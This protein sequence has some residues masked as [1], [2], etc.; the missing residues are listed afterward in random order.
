MLA[1][2]NR[3]KRSSSVNV[4]STR[5]NGNSYDDNDVNCTEVTASKD[6]S[7]REFSKDFTWVGTAWYCQNR[8]KHYKSFSR[9]GITIS[10]HS[11]VYIMSEEMKRLVAYV[12]DLYEDTNSYNMVK[13]RWFDKVDEVGVPLPMDVN[14][15]EIFFS[16]GRQ[17]L[18]V[19][20]IDGLA[21]VLSAQ[22]FEK[23]KN[24][25]KY[26]NWEPYLCRWQID[27]DEVKPFDISQLQG[28]WSQEV[29]RTMFNAASSLKVRFR[30]TKVGPSCDGGQKRK[31]DEF[32]N[33]A[34]PQKF[35][36]SGASGSDFFK[37]ALYDNRKHIY[38]G[39][40]AEVLSQDSGIR[41]CWFR[42]LILKR[43]RDK[44]KVRYLDLQDADDTG[45]LEEWVMLTRV[46]KPDHLGIRFIGRPM[47]R[48]QRVQ[49]IKVPS[50][51]DVG[52]IVDAWWH[53][54]WW[55]G[56]VL[57][58]GNDRRL[59]VYFPGEKRVAEFGEDDLRYSLEWVGSKWNPLKE[60]KDIANKLSSTAYSEGEGLI[61][62]QISHK[63]NPSPKPESQMEGLQF[64]RCDDKLYVSK[65]S[66]D[67]KRVLADLTNDLKFDNLKWRPRKR[68][69]RSG[70]KRQ[71]DTS[72]GSSSQERDMESSSPS[73]S[74]VQ[75]NS[76][77]DEEICKSSGEQ[78]FMGVPVQVSNL[79]MSR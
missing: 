18:S 66:R 30:V 57:R 44:I 13:V 37:D 62:K 63:G 7:S 70:S 73:G 3:E 51:F 2:G 35:L 52:A 26:S 10:V 68:S 42:C 24:G 49:D 34:S 50:I 8:W 48:P 67:Q 74:F 54:G 14:D 25:I 27:N 20:C 32:D 39:C 59:Q 4:N 16:L 65:I 1:F 23:F 47:V 29:L 17:D 43:H 45:N 33:D 71:S 60:R 38:P 41:G 79:V 46:A 28:Y 31:R 19:E 76:A 75:L 58:Q 72:S 22:Q 78:R 9:R 64:Q 56:I 36:C 53:D 55:E 69:R 6:V 40:H 61:G 5:F 77:T 15:R 12:E 21:A 11:F